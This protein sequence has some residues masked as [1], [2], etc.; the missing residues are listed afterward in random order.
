[1]KEH[2]QTSGVKAQGSNSERSSR[3]TEEGHP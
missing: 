3:S 2:Q 1:M